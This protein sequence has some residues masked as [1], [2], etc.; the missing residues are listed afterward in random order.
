MKLKRA[1]VSSGRALRNPGKRRLAAARIDLHDEHQFGRLET[2][3]RDAVAERSFTQRRES[4][5]ID[6]E[7]AEWREPNRALGKLRATRAERPRR[8][9]RER[10]RIRPVQDRD[11]E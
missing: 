4:L 6:L 8:K 5:E 7:G 1:G 2:R 3:R 9:G 11:L 10:A